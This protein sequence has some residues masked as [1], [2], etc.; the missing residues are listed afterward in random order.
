MLSVII[1]IGG[2]DSTNKELKVKLKKKITYIEIK[3]SSEIQNL[4]Y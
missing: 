1:L 4:D 2:L 3:I